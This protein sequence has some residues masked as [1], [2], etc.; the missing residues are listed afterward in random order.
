MLDVYSYKDGEQVVIGTLKYWGAR[1]VKWHRVQ[2]LE[3][4]HVCSRQTHV[5]WGWPSPVESTSHY[6][7]WISD[8][9]L[10]N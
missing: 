10:Q 5:G 9:E 3:P 4:A 6:M 2:N 8:L 7:S 1:N